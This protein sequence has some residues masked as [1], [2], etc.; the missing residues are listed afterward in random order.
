MTEDVVIAD[1]DEP[2]IDV[3]AR[4]GDEG[5]HLRQPLGEDPAFSVLAQVLQ[6]L[7]RVH[8][9]LRSMVSRQHGTRAVAGDRDVGPAL[10]AGRPRN[11]VGRHRPSGRPALTRMPTAADAGGNET[12][13]E[14]PMSADETIHIEPMACTAID[15][16]LLRFRGR[17]LVSGS[18]VVD[19][20]LD[21]RIAVD[22]ERRLGQ[23]LT[24]AR[25]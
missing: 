7:R 20:L 25:S 15:D 22:A 12:E 23:V 6:E 5:E 8:D 2:V 11:T 3:A 17:T 19:V 9:P 4:M 16:A 1:P 10:P 21:L 14:G 13:R 18:E 24:P